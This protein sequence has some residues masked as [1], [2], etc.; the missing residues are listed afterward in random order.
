MKKEDLKKVNKYKGRLWKKHSSVNLSAAVSL[1]LF[2]FH[3]SIP[4]T[5]G[6]A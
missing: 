2:S 5:E 4:D 1:T 3:R 6:K